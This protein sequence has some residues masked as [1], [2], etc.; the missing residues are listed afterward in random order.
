MRQHLT[1]I[2]RNAAWLAVGEGTVKGALFLAAAVI[3]RGMGP[4]GMGT[5][6]IGY[7]AAL[8]A[9]MVM[10]CGQQE[11][12]IRE[13]ARRPSAA[14]LVLRA[15]RGVQNRTAA[16]P[17]LLGIWVVSSLTERELALTVA[18]FLPYAALRTV[19]VTHGAAFK[20][21][22]RMDVEVRARALEAVIAL[23]LL[24][25]CAVLGW[26]VWTTGPAFAAGAGVALAWIASR[27]R[28]LPA[29]GSRPSLT[30]LAAEGLP[31]LGLA[32]LGQLLM[33]ADTF[34]LE[35]LG[36]ARQQIGLYGA[37][38]APVWGLAAL[39]QLAAVAAYPTLSRMARSAA[40][41]ASLV[42]GMA[43]V[44]ALGGC[45]LAVGL[46]ILRRP[47]VLLAFGRDFAPAAELL[48]RLAWVLPSA[49]AM[50]LLGV[51]LAAWR[52]QRWSLAVLAVMA[53][54]LAGLDLLL[55]PQAGA[56]GAA[57]ASVL[58]RAGGAVLLVAVAWRVT[59]R[60]IQETDP[61]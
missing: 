25:A 24:A 43:A 51:V 49:V 45:G 31:F 42:A 36:V 21:L 56:L 57:T 15:A 61:L 16:V 2:G 38:A 17:V 58:V 18:L 6:T 46:A 22:D 41:P 5:F 1:L 47:L 35:A 8:L 59:R 30:G 33:R 53:P 34:L 10:A 44:G 13:V 40:A 32:V 3:A 27:S 28:F 26:P 37:A 48:A 12:T 50:T 4:H 7:A 39:P 54:C 14:R 52:R 23:P 55:I 60:P 11:V 9:V 19:T 29:T 20:G